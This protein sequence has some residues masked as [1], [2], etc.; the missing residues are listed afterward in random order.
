MQNVNTGWSQPQQQVTQGFVEKAVLCRAP[1]YQT[2]YR[3]PLSANMGRTAQLTL[4]EIGQSTGG[5]DK[6]ALAPVA[7]TM[8]MP[9]TSVESIAGID[10]GWSSERCILNLKVVHSV[11]HDGSMKLVQYLTGYTNH[12]GMA[13]AANQQVVIDPNMWVYFNN[14]LIYQEARYMD[15]NGVM[16]TRITPVDATQLIIGM[17]SDA[18]TGT[19]DITVRPSDVY[20]AINSRT[21]LEQANQYDTNN[22]GHSRIGAMY[23]TRVQF[24][25]GMP[26][27]K[28]SRE[29]LSP[30]GYLSR[31]LSSA[32]DIRVQNAGAYTDATT[33]SGQIQSSLS[34]GY[35]SNDSTLSA[36]LERTGMAENR[37]VTWNELRTLYPNID[38][39]VV[40]A[41]ME[42]S[43]VQGAVGGTQSATF[44][45]G[46]YSVI[47]ANTIYNTASSIM[48]DMMISTVQLAGNNMSAGCATT[49]MV[50]GDFV[51]NVTFLRP[52]IDG[53]LDYMLAE[54]FKQRLVSEFLIGFTRQNHV[55][56][57]FNIK[58]SMFGES[59]I[60]ISYNNEPSVRYVYP[61]FCDSLYTPIITSNQLHLN[62]LATE[63][64]AFNNTVL[65]Q[66]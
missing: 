44:D 31:L 22:G 14:S 19:K 3:R 6:M 39:V 13:M 48:M 43:Q 45:A 2:M 15:G 23:D 50:A 26:Y 12:M 40:K 63:T 8:L 9:S 21:L 65:R 1:G 46:N 27:K 51:T 58:M 28:S 18:Q 33:T 57:A 37:Y 34:E 10:N 36:L 16:Q 56:I 25:S 42:S 49:G 38:S 52:F 30:A 47:M 53:S 59:I 60:D 61:A 4:A 62:T 20:S 11:N 32:N 54:G 55:P 29:N 5:F 64:R 24:T 17:P 7:A 66:L 35:L 41:G